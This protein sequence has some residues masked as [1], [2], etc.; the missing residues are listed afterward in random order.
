MVTRRPGH[1][2]DRL[3]RRNGVVAAAS[4]LTVGLLFLYPA[5]TNATGTPR[6]AGQA[7]APAGIV[8][9]PPAA[10]ADPTA[11]PTADTPDGIPATEPPATVAPAPDTP[12]APMSTPKST[13]TPAP[14]T[15]TVNGAAA[16]SGYGPVQVQLLV[17]GTRIVSATAIDYPQ[18]SGRDR[19]INTHA[20]PI[21]QRETLTAQS[22]RID[23]VSGA[24]YT[25]G[26]YQQS[27]QSAL[28]AAHL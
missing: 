8:A 26:A 22:S 20:V 10:L 19:R 4:T 24:T 6:R 5:S 21:L 16:E 11:P 14:R 25:S 18:E 17:R 23:T 28:D 9:G 7:T 1:E 15:F 12:P 27:L 2:H 3:A 13:P